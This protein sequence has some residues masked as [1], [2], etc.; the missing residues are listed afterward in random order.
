M[1]GGH[2]GLEHEVTRVGLARPELCD[3]LGR[4]GVVDLAKIRMSR[5]LRND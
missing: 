5:K 4:F 2:I 1:A 3:P